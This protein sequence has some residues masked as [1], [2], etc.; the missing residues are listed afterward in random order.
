MIRF[1]LAHHS[2]SQ[3]QSHHGVEYYALSYVWGEAT[4]ME[5]V[6]VNNERV[7]V[8][9]TLWHFLCSLR[10]IL[11]DVSDVNSP[12]KSL[13]GKPADRTFL[14]IHFLCIY[15]HQTTMKFLGTLRFPPQFFEDFHSSELG[16]QPHSK[17]SG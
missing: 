14:W 16:I 1:N 7:E 10:D 15:S 13:N 17:L 2:L 4:N 5:I 8:R 12:F 11:Q 6:E 3:H 9:S